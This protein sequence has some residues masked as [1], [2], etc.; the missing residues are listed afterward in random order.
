MIDFLRL[1]HLLLDFLRKACQNP[2]QS[3]GTLAAAVLLLVF[4]AAY[5]IL[6]MIDWSDAPTQT[7]KPCQ[8]AIKVGKRASLEVAPPGLKAIVKAH[9][10]ALQVSLSDQLDYEKNTQRVLCDGEVFKEGVKAFLEKRK[11]NF[12]DI[13]EV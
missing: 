6:S 4:A 3:L 5:P 13:E 8:K 12:R 11:P 9:D 2:F 1:P 7:G 10:N